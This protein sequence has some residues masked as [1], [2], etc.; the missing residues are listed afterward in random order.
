[1]RLRRGVYASVEEYRGLSREDKYL[2]RVA[3]AASIRNDPVLAGLS[4]AVWLGLPLVGSVPQYVYLLSPANN[5]R[6]RNGVIELPRRGRETVIELD[7]LR[8]TSI[9]DTLIEVCRTVPFVTALA[10]IDAALLVDRFGK[11]P[12]LVSFDELM[13]A[14]QERM[15]YRGSVRVRGVLV[16]ATT[17]AESAF[18]T[19]SRVTIDELGFPEPELQ[20]EI[21]LNDGKTV[22]SDFGW[23]DYRAVGEADGWGKYIDP[24]HPSSATLEERVRAEKRRDNAIRRTGLTPAHWEWSDAWDREPLRRILL[25]AGLPI[26]RRPRTIR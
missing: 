21:V 12:P 1:M 18:E 19:L 6:K 23:P 16:A 22:Y 5:G 4:A 8:T 25:D 10:M 26:V 13:A 17:A 9:A 2:T 20:F 24:K 14:H 3:G 15:P 11:E 7:G